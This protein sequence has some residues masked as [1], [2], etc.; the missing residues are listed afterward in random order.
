MV[1]ML[2]VY[3][4]KKAHM[5]NIIT[6]FLNVFKSMIDWIYRPLVS[7]MTDMLEYVQEDLDT[8]N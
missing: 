6:V 2:F 8:Q 5:F 7:W 1:A 4:G 3:K